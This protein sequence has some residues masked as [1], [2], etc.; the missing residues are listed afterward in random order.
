MFVRACYPRAAAGLDSFSAS[1][2]IEVDRHVREGGWQVLGG[3]GQRRIALYAPM[4]SISVISMA[5]S[6]APTAMMACSTAKTSVDCPRHC[7]KREDG[8]DPL[9]ICRARS[10]WSGS[11]CSSRCQMGSPDPP[12]VVLGAFPAEVG[13]C[14]SVCPRPEMGVARWQRGSKLEL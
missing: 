5:E 6:A 8:G 9:A 3:W 7:S 12:V 2:Q 10:S 13:R 14:C 11:T 1:Q 4:T